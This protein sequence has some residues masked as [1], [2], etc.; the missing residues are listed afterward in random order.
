MAAMTLGLD[1]YR[2]L[3]TSPIR[4][5]C[6]ISSRTAGG[7][8]AAKPLRTKPGTVFNYS[9]GTAVLISR[10]W[11]DR[12]GDAKGRAQLPARRCSFRSG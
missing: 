3:A 4:P 6:S 9:T 2:G 7:S 10:L 1:D 11:M 5:A 8:V 12:I